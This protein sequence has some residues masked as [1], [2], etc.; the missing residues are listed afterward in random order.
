MNSNNFL[1]TCFF[2]KV[3]PKNDIQECTNHRSIASFR[4]GIFDVTAMDTNKFWK[5]DNFLSENSA[6]IASI[7][8]YLLKQP[9]FNFPIEFYPFFMFVHHSQIGFKFIDKDGNAIRHMILQLQNS[10]YPS[11]SNTKPFD[12]PTTCKI[13]NPD[14][15]NDNDIIINLDDR[16]AVYGDL[17]EQKNNISNNIIEMNKYTY[18][19]G[20]HLKFLRKFVNFNFFLQSYK[21]WRNV[22]TLPNPNP[23]EG[24]TKLNCN[25]TD[26]FCGG[27]GDGSL[28]VFNGFSPAFLSENE[29]C[30]LHFATIKSNSNNN[31][32]LTNQFKN[33][34]KWNFSNLQ[35]YNNIETHNNSFSKHYTTLSPSSLNYNWCINNSN[36]D[37][38]NT[39]FDKLRPKNSKP[40]EWLSKK[41][42][43]PVLDPSCRV[44]DELM[45]K[46]I[47][48]KSFTQ[49]ETM[50]NPLDVANTNN[51]PFL[52]QGENYTCE[53]YSRFVVT[54]LLNDNTWNS[55][56]DVAVNQ[57]FDFNFTNKTEND[58]SFADNLFRAY[59]MYWPVAIFDDG[60]ENG[61]PQSTFNTDKK[62]M[63]DKIM[64]AKQAQLFK[65]IFN[66]DLIEASKTTENP[67]LIVLAE[68]LGLPK[69]KMILNAIL[70]KDNELT[71][72]Q[73]KTLTTVLTGILYALFLHNFL[74]VEEVF[75]PGYPLRKFSA[76]SNQYEYV[77]VYDCEPSIYKFQIGKSSRAGIAN[78]KCVETLLKWITKETN[79]S[80]Q[81]PILNIKPE[82]D[83]VTKQIKMDF[84]NAVSEYM[85]GKNGEGNIDPV[86]ACKDSS[87]PFCKE[88]VEITNGITNI[89]HYANSG[90]D[91][92]DAVTK[93][94]ENP[95]KISTIF[96]Q[97]FSNY[98]K[99]ISDKIF[100]ILTLYL[101]KFTTICHQNYTFNPQILVQRNND[102]KTPYGFA[103]FKRPS[104][105]IC[106]N[107]KCDIDITNKPVQLAM[108]SNNIKA[109]KFKAKFKLSNPY[110][111]TK[112]DYSSLGFHVTL[113]I[114]ILLFISICIFIGLKIYNNRR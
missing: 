11:L 78:N 40:A 45:E 31:N 113:V 42:W 57:L 93:M 83:D 18:F 41:G 111:D 108:S 34:I 46:I 3:I 10:S 1:N 61:V 56:K 106:S 102:L 91:I 64:Y 75:V 85:K 33:F 50:A 90:A 22:N 84:I 25:Q 110:Q 35:C 77:D 30:I 28:F 68:F 59:S 88:G 66:N 4:Q 9:L 16:T 63:S 29:G 105:G 92:I 69:L 65:Y 48:G 54:M 98:I 53:I 72:S 21:L 62:Y 7:E 38:V 96:V 100:R 81:N 73:F 74:G 70:G 107:L 24:I 58:M 89:K 13:I 47:N 71:D 60:Y 101:G 114:C 19:K 87:I 17:L 43:D 67:I 97:S 82:D 52:C 6:N 20:I 104:E 14:D 103:D 32:N 49:P 12:L 39:L 2:D 23:V 36:V 109:K 80:V 44:F 95:E 86:V 79:S 15:K 27:S 8:C 37:D 5:I 94:I 51:C 55:D 76:T 99:N 112:K 26:G